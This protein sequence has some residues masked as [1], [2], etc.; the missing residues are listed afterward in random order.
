MNFE[1]DNLNYFDISPVISSQTAVFPGDK[2]FSRHVSLDFKNGH[3]LELS[4]IETT[5][6][7]GAHADAPSHYWAQG[8]SI[9]KRSLKYYLGQT[10]VIRL[11]LERGER[12]LP[13]HI[14][15]IPIRVPRVLLAT[16][17][18][19]D[20]E[21]WNDDFNS[22]SP[23]LVEYLHSHNVITVGIDTPS[24]DPANSKILEAHRA[25]AERNMAVLEGLI[26][27]QV[28]EGIYTMIALPLRIKDGEAS[29]VRAVLL[30]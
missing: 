8:E 9:E 17:S 11:K 16:N 2:P 20:P 5:L 26:L 7:M 27:E 29:P 22:L 1:T 15:N 12:I 24:V 3:H 19:P 13:K 23:E 10:Q 25:I 6:H 28:P 21:S 14:E 4:F 30:H 18:F